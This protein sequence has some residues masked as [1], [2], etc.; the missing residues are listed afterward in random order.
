MDA[1]TRTGD[2][3]ACWQS[4]IQLRILEWF[5]DPEVYHSAGKMLF[6]L[7]MLE[8][9][10]LTGRIYGPSNQPSAETHEWFLVLNTTR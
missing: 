6:F 4:I 5:S 2:D 3:K 8:T 1:K 9:A 10:D 7:E